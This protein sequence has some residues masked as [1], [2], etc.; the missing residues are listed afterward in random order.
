M[1]NLRVART[2]SLRSVDILKDRVPATREHTADVEIWAMSMDLKESSLELK[3]FLGTAHVS[4]QSPF[5]SLDAAA[6][7]DWAELMI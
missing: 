1:A 3:C 5:V 7:G 4:F 2:Q 6:S